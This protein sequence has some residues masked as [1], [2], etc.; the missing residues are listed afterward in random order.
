MLDST[1]DRFNKIYIYLLNIKGVD[2]VK[3]KI[4]IAG[5]GRSGTTLLLKLMRCFEDVHTVR[6]E[7]EISEFNNLEL[8]VEEKSIV[9]K[10]K[11]WAHKGLPDISSD[12]K[13]IYCVR[14]PADVLTSK[15][16]KPNK[17]VKS[18][19]PEY[20]I[21]KDRWVS[22]FDAYLELIRRQLKREISIVRYED[23][24]ENPDDVQ[25]LLAKNLDLEPRVSFQ[26]NDIGVSIAKGSV[27]KYKKDEKMKDY[28]LGLD[29]EFKL[30]INYFLGLFGYDFSEVFGDHESLPVSNT[31]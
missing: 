25:R 7:E 16:R 27:R 19:T 5:C 18:S 21:T 1:I 2:S 6:V 8:V 15:L 12:I 13:L 28:L 11:A 22:E 31:R 26:D 17:R 23:L 10:R 20:Y 24:I 29:A 30:K 14:H 9:I 3:N 4:F